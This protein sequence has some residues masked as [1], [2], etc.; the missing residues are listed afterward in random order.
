VHLPTSYDCLVGALRRGAAW[1][2]EKAKAEAR[3]LRVGILGGSFSA[4]GAVADLADS[5][6][7]VLKGLLLGSSF[8]SYGVEVVNMAQGG[9]GFMLPLFCTDKVGGDRVWQLSFLL[10]WPLKYIAS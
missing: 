1:Q 5:Y 9:A 3:P 10:A 6:T 7:E 4:G 2:M 8:L